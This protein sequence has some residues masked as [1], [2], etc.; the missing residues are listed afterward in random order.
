MEHLKKMDI[1]PYLLKVGLM[2]TDMAQFKDLN[3]EYVKYFGLKP[4]VRVCVAIPGHE[5]IAFFIAWNPALGDLSTMQ[6]QQENLHVQSV[7]Y[8]APPNIGPYSQANKF[9][10]GILLAGQ[11]GLYAPKLCLV[12]PNDIILQYRQLSI[13]YNQVLR[14]ILQ[15]TT[16]KWQDIAKS[17]IVYVSQDASIDEL[18]KIVGSDLKQSKNGLLQR[19]VLVRV[20][21][22]PMNALVEVEMICDSISVK[23]HERNYVIDLAKH[24]FYDTAQSFQSRNVLDN[25]FGEVFYVQNLVQK[26]EICQQ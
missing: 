21:Q 24:N 6:A 14:E 2:V 18:L 13:N 26:S 15:N 9:K 7:S 17:V 1:L 12:D 19:S 10:N 23:A 20:S 8:W 4:P 22:L 16:T 5:V 25:K 3:A 11:I